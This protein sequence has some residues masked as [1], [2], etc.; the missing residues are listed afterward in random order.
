MPLIH[1]NGRI[2]LANLLQS[3]K[4]TFSCVSFPGLFAF[5]EGLWDTHISALLSSPTVSGSVLKVEITAQRR[6]LTAINAEAW[7]LSR[8]A[9]RHIWPTTII[10][11]M[12]SYSAMPMAGA[13]QPV[14]T[15]G[16]SIVQVACDRQQTC[17]TP[18]HSET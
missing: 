7:R 1:T 12:I 17:V 15:R 16:A 8:T 14:F 4:S 11:K 6:G 2:L 5:Q 18:S 9:Y 10:S 13:A 3:S